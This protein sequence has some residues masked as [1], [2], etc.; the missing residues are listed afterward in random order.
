MMRTG[1]LA[2]STIASSALLLA[3]VDGSGSLLSKLASSNHVTASTVPSNGDL[4]PYGTA[5]VPRDFRTGGPLQP[6]DLLVSNFNNASNLQGTGTTIV[7]ITPK[8]KVSL[9]FESKEAVGLTTALGVLRSGFILVGNVPTKDGTFATIGRGS[10]LVINRFGKQVGELR[11]DRLLDGPWDLALRDEGDWAQVFVSNVLDG[12]VTRLTLKFHDDGFELVGRT[13]I[14]SGYLHRS[15]PAALV[16]G[17]TGLAYDRSRDVLFVASTDDN[18]VFAIDDAGDLREDRGRGHI[19]VSDQTHLH[20]PL[21]LVLTPQG[22]LIV[23][24][25]D[26]VNPDPNHP[27]ELDEFSLDGDFLASFTVDTTPGSAFGI[28]LAQHGDDIRFAAVDDNTNSVT[29]WDVEE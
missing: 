24:N 13:R 14:G 17:P 19:V 15:D 8:G 21:G 23:A 12:T 2:L 25:G 7:R 27:S 20:G 11:N 22:H 18:A 5:F 28:A 10:V 26:A 6:G 3:Q 16:V 9:F 4:N 29:I 1:F